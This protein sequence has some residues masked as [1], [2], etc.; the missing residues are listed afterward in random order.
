FINTEAHNRLQS[1]GNDQS[2]KDC[3]TERDSNG[4]ELLDP[5]RAAHDSFKIRVQVRIH[6]AGCQYPR[7]ERAERSAH[8]MDAEGVQGII[9]TEP[10]FEFVA[11]EE[12]NQTGGDADDD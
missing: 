6:L 8:S 7:Q 4:F 2:A 5:E 10:A 3:Q 9:V 1:V 12:R 11:G